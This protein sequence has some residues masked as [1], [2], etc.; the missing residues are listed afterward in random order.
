MTGSAGYLIGPV[1][2]K[3]LPARTT[4]ESETR[5]RCARQSNPVHRDNSDVS[6][7]LYICKKCPPDL[8]D[9]V[10]FKGRRQRGVH[11]A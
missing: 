7:K 11:G 9:I 5:E 1:C 8:T 3:E 2:L 10:A 4:L 6:V